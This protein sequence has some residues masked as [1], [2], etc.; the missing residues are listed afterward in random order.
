MLAFHSSNLDKMEHTNNIQE[1]YNELA[2]KYD[3]NRFGNSYGQYIHQQE[4]RILQKILKNTASERILDIG[5]GTGRLTDFA[6]YGLDISA[7]MIEEAKTKFPNKQFSVE[8]AIKTD[9]EDVF[10]DKLFSFHVIM[11]Q[12]KNNTKR[13]LD[14]AHRILK[15]E[16]QFIFDFPSLK[17][18]KLIN[19]KAANWHAANSFSIEEMKNLVGDR[20]KLIATYGFL[21]LP[22]HRIPAKIRPFLI[23]LD[24]LLCSLFKEYASYITIVLSKR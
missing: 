23:P 24:N 11:H 2:P 19:Y 13:I 20:W 7:A 4:I 18:R 10:F 5:C 3:V 15:K 12:D 22:I 6:N 17:R 16:G 14:E 21:W 1:Y 8:S 9:F